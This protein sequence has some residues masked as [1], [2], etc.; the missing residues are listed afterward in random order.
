M[1]D[2]TLQRTIFARHSNELSFA[3][4]TRPGLVFLLT[5]KKKKKKREKKENPIERKTRDWPRHFVSF[6]RHTRSHDKSSTSTG[7]SVAHVL[8]TR[9]APLS[10]P[11]DVHALPIDS[12]PDNS[13]INFPRCGRARVIISRREFQRKLVRS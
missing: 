1:E 7:T 5:G 2:F 10:R 9:A 8:S 11:I 13:R 4:N 6:S 3:R 12:P